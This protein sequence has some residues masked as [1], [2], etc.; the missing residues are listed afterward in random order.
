MISDAGIKASLFA[1]ATCIDVSSSLVELNNED[2]T[3]TLE[4]VLLMK[5]P[6]LDKEGEVISEDGPLYERGARLRLPWENL[7]L[8]SKEGQVPTS[9]IRVMP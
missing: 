7:W 4:V 9:T 6:V 2:H 1:N 3:I 8:V 5:S